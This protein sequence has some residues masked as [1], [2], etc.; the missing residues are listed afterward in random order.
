MLRTHD[1]NDIAGEI[2]PCNFPNPLSSKISRD[3][4]DQTVGG[5]E[6]ERVISITKDSFLNRRSGHR[7]P[8][9]ERAK[10]EIN[11]DTS[12]GFFPST[13]ISR[14]PRGLSSW[15][16]KDSATSLKRSAKLRCFEATVRN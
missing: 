6:G 11:F 9:Y 3:H 7:F 16:K 5:C 14:Y 1:P 13:S 10:S 8:L 2:L 15:M 12:T 4:V